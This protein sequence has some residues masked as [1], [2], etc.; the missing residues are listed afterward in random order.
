L[1]EGQQAERI[2]AA[3]QEKL[4]TPLGL[5]SLAPGHPDY[6]PHYEG[7]VWQRD[8]AYHQGTVWPWLIGPFV[9][10][11]IR[12]RGSTQKSGREAREAFIAPLLAHLDD[13]GLGHVSEIADA[14]LPHT[15]RGCPFQAW[16]VGELLRLDQVV[17][18]EPAIQ[19]ARKAT[20]KPVSN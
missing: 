8:G 2:V 13:A 1:F 11:W 15:P 3:V 12:V 20:R 9:E 14:E 6:K 10:A 17:L 4:L 18:A 19:P 7:G 5:R 16:S